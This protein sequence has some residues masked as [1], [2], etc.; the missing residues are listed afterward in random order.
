MKNTRVITMAFK[1]KFK[2][3]DRVW[4][5]SPRHDHFMKVGRITGKRDLRNP[6][7]NILEIWSCGGFLT[8]WVKFTYYFE[9]EDL[10]LVGEFGG[11]P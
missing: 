7:L 5:L 4:I 6:R 1:R 11:M 2:R 8:R 9:D 10:S 3:N